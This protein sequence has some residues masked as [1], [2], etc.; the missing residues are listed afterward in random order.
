[1]GRSSGIQFCGYIS[2]PF[3]RK[4]KLS[5]K[6]I[7]QAIQKFVFNVNIASRWGGQ[8]PFVNLT[9]DWTVPDDLKKQPVVWGGKLLEESYSQY[10]KE[11]NLI[12]KAF[13]E[14]L[15]EGDMKGRPFTF[16]I[17][18]YNLTRDLNWENENAKFLF[19][20]TAKYGL[21]YFSNFINSDLNPGEVR[22]M[23]CRLRLNLRQLDRNVTGGLFG[24]GDSTGSVGVVTINMPRIAYLSKNKEEFLDRLEYLMGLAK[25]S[26]E[27][28][29]KIVEKNMQ[30]G[31]LPYTK[32]YLR[33]LKNH[34]STIGPVG[35]NEACLNL[36]GKDIASPE[37]KS[38]AIETLKFMRA[39][40]S[41]FQEETS[42]IYN[43]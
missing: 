30:G 34:F 10:Q 43:T 20:M 18:T 15:I 24:S 6:E 31:L 26:L 32:R 37:G 36:L 7:K 5:Y 11:M 12:N 40:L 8:S 42:H 1:V 19:D 22:S 35:M 25:S 3:I 17:P 4:D 23:C 9:F 21:P 38:L 14:V 39:R 33:T 2:A 29:R 13:M 27:T 16:P 41:D 28:K